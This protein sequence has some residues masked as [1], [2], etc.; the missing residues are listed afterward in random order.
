[1]SFHLALAE[2]GGPLGPDKEVTMALSI[3]K[4]YHKYVLVR[5]PNIRLHDTIAFLKNVSTLFF[6][7]IYARF[8]LYTGTMHVYFA[9]LA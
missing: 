3:Q 1:M 7:I 4:M 8:N 2:A 5:G 9:F 6:N